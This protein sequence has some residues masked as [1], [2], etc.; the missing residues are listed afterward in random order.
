M[1]QAEG[2]TTT[3]INLARVLAQDNKKVV[4]IDCDMR[5]PAAHTRLKRQNES[6]LSDYLSGNVNKLRIQRIPGEEIAFISSGPIPPNPA[7]LLNSKRMEELVEKLSQRCDFILLDS[8]PIQA[9]SDSLALCRIVDGTI[10]VVRYGKTTYDKLTAGMKKLSDIKA[11]VLGF[12][13]NR[14]IHDGTSRSYYTNYYTYT[15]KPSEKN[16]G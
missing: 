6:G 11:H 1:D 2:K 3:S 9:V 13:L 16:P 12:V 15:E 4:L 7:E 5:K 8:P 10:I 14:Y